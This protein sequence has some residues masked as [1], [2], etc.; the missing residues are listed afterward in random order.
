MPALGMAQESGVLIR[1]LVP[2]GGTVSEGEPLMEVETDKAVVEVPAT[3]SGTL[4]AVAYGEGAEVAVGTV[5]AVVLAPGEAVDGRVS[6]GPGKVS[7]PVSEPSAAVDEMAPPRD[8]SELEALRAARQT[9][10]VPSVGASDHVVTVG[11]RTVVLASPKAKRL[12]RERGLDLTQLVGRGPAGAVRAADLPPTGSAGRSPAPG[13][14][15]HGAVVPGAWLRGSVDATGLL[16]FVE[17][18]GRH[19][20]TPDRRVAIADV[21]TRVVAAGLARDRVVGSRAT[22]VR[23][24]M[25]D[26]LGGVTTLPLSHRHLGSIRAVAAARLEGSAEPE[27]S[28]AAASGVSGTLSVH[29]VD[30]SAEQFERSPTALED[31]MAVRVTLGPIVDTLAVAAGVPSR[32]MGATVQLDYDTRVLDEVRAAALITYVSRLIGDPFALVVQG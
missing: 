5:L 31:G 17:R 9:A 2:E 10:G 1:W 27:P 20:A 30:R 3:A 7:A 8:A 18:V 19:T 11:S 32:R 14:A 12:A 28:A 24:S 22:G 6:P 16:E 25:H 21:L 26:A 4:A 29:V 15:S 23:L 13:A